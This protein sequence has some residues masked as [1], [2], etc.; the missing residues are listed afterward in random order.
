[1][2]A[3]LHEESAAIESTHWWYQGRRR[4][5][6]DVLKRSLGGRPHRILDVGCGTGELVEML[7]EFGEVTGMDSSP[8]AVEWCR[9]RLG[10]RAE[11]VVGDVPAGLPARA[12]FDVVTAFDVLEHLDDDGA[13]LAAIFGL[14][15]PGGIFA[16]TVPAYM[17]LWS[18]HDDINHHRRRYTRR[19]LI[20]RLRAAGFEVQRSSYFNTWLLPVVAGVRLVRRSRRAGAVAPPQD[21]AVGES[22]FTM[23]PPWVNS[24]VRTVFASERFVLRAMPLPA[25]V[26]IVAVCRKC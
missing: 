25:G 16:C 7:T 5:I 15:P 13:A 14:L 11:L 3:C 24:I 12:G 9:K 20:R 2:D 23:P 18:P 1:M 8:L 17:A 19:Q 10:G 21:S 4:I 6:Q 26:S 22:D